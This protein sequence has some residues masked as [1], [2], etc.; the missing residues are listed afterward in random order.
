MRQV[1]QELDKIEI[2]GIKPSVASP[3]KNNTIIIPSF[4]PAIA[5]KT[6]ELS[7]SPELYWAKYDEPKNMYQ[8]G[9]MSG[10]SAQFSHRMT[11]APQSIINMFRIQGQWASG[12]FKQAPDQGPSG[13][14]DSTFDIRGVVG[15]DFYPSSYLRTTGYFGFG[16]RYLKDNSEG[17]ITVTDEYTLQGYKRFSHYCYLPLGADIVYQKY[18]NSSFESNLEYDYMFNGWQVSKLGDIP[19]YSTLVVDQ[20][21]GYGL[22]ASLRLNLYF[23][24]FTAFAEGFY[25][26]WKIAQSN[27]KV[28]PTDPTA[29]LYEPRNNTQEYGLRIGLQ[30]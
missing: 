23:K 9:F 12:K 16:Y 1:N 28:D 3:S 4:K 8:K 20:R 26:Y 17:L 15:K 5:P 25:R 13:I 2:S 24:Y 10:Y 21:G 14:K 30:I 27:S 22:R 6:N 7:F 19:G 11:S 18:P 29:V